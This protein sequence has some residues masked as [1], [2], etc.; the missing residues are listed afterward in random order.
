MEMKIL[1]RR[2]TAQVYETHMVEDFPKEERKPLSMILDGY[3]KGDCCMYGFFEGDAL[4]AYACLYGTKESREPALLDYLAV[5]PAYRDRGLGSH[6][7][8]SLK[9]ELPQGMMIE[10]E[11]IHAAQ[12]PAEQE[13]RERRIRFYE[14]NGARLQPFETTLFGVR[15][16][17]LTLGGPENMDARQSMEALYRRMLQ[18]YIPMEKALLF[19]DC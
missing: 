17:I 9:T 2:E 5:V 18:G 3:D 19:H 16:S 7:L 13:T 11:A 15:F 12:T 14:R 1:D 10:A 8:A 6:V 4:M